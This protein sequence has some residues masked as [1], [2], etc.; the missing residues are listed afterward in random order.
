RSRP[1]TGR[2]ARSWAEF[3]SRT[4]PARLRSSDS[5]ESALPQL[6]GSGSALQVSLRLHT[7]HVSKVESSPPAFTKTGALCL[8]WIM[9]HMKSRIRYG[10]LVGR[11]AL[12]DYS[13]DRVIP[14]L[15]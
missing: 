7:A 11:V 6:W 14:P 5:V 13:A 9:S 2:S 8:G 1:L 12:R 10:A 4:I 3:K 15:Q